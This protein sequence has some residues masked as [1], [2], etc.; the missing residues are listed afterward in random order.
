M[1]NLSLNTWWDALSGGGQFFWALAIVSSIVFILV[2]VISLLGM[3]ADTDL[4]IDTDGIDGD[5]DFPIF[6]VKS[7]TAFLTFFS[8]TGVMMLDAGKSVAQLMP[9]SIGAGLVAM[10]TVVFL[11]RQ[12]NKFTESGTADFL[13]LIFEKGDV[14]LTIPPDKKGKGKIHITLNDSLKEINAITEGPEI[15]SGEKV[16]ILEIMKDNTLLVEKINQLK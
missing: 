10:F 3:D 13:D 2:F 1:I 7:I 9:F 5:F 12:F 11:V 14:Y 16:R 6:G 4:E 8:W 15:K